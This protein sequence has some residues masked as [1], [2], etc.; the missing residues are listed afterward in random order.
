MAT[1]LIVDDDER[2]RRAIAAVL[3]AERHVVLEAANGREGLELARSGYPDVVLCDVGMPEMDGYELLDRLRQGASTST[4]PVILMTGAPEQHDMRHSMERGAD[5][6]LPKPFDTSSLLAA[7]RMRLERKRAT[8]AQLQEVRSRLLGIVDAT[9]NLV[10]MAHSDTLAV[11]YCNPAGRKMLGIDSSTEMVP[12]CLKNHILD[13]EGRTEFENWFAIAKA[14]GKWLGEC[15]IKSVRG[16]SLPVELQI[17]A[18][19]VEAGRPEYVSILAHDQSET[20]QLRQAQKME[21]IGRLA[22]GIAHEINTPIQFTEN[23]LQFLQQAFNALQQTVT[24]LEAAVR[25]AQAG[26]VPGELLARAVA[27]LDQ[28]DLGY[29]AQEIPTALEEARHGTARVAKIVTAMKEFS[30]P[31]RNLRQQAEPVDLARAMES[32]IMVARNE[33]KYVAEV[34]TD[35]EAPMPPVPLYAGEFNQVILNLLVNA[36]HAV[37]DATHGGSE[38]KGTIK[39]ST[40]RDGSWAEILVSDTGT[41]IPEAVQHRVFEPFFTTKEIGRGTGQ[42]LALARS[43]IVERHR[44]QIS[45]ESQTGKGTCFRIRVPL[46]ARGRGP[47][48]TRQ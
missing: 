30:H 48:L 3:Q 22:A 20:L 43:I 27:A 18:P 28:A 1:I 32:A 31:G 37:S 44:G 35:F 34:V 15:L 36:A 29:L 2:A 11:W 4:L 14:E 23:N 41:G 39:V 6:Y 16:G 12:L 46:H 25:A 5:D 40:R 42:G 8:A 17:L 45:F 26:P 13:H 33:W 47:G 38:G 9:P 7:V 21:A 24:L 10:A 19:R